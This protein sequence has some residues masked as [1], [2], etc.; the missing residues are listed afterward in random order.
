M[1]PAGPDEPGPTPLAPP[2]GAVLA[3]R[4]RVLEALGQGGMGVVVRALDLELS[5]EVALKLLVGSEG[6]QL[7]RMRREG[8]VA[9]SLRHPGIVTLHELGEHEGRP[10]LVYELVERAR[11]LGGLLEEAP[12]ERLLGWVLDA[13]RALAF[14]HARG[15]VHRDVKPDNLLIDGEGRLR[16]ADFGLATG[17]QV[18]RLTRSGQR[19]GTPRYMSPEQARGDRER[20]G[21]PA[22]VWGLGVIL[23]RVLTGRLPFDTA[24]SVAELMAQIVHREPPPILGLDPSVPPGL[25]AVC[26]RALSKAPERRYAD[27]GELADDLARALASPDFAP[28]APREASTPA[29]LRGLLIAGMA[30]AAVFLV[31]AP[32]LDPLPAGPAGG[33][34]P[35]ESASVPTVASTLPR[36]PAWVAALPAEERPPL[37]LPPGLA[38][39]EGREVVNER[40]GSRL[41]WIPP[42]RFTR[43]REDP[44]HAEEGPVHAVTLRRGLFLGVH[45]LDWGRYR[46][47]C[48]ATARPLPSPFLVLRVRLE[49]RELE[50]D[51]RPFQDDHPVMNVCW[52]D[53][54]DYCDWAGLRLPSEAEWERAAR[55][56]DTRPYPWGWDPPDAGRCNSLRKGAGAAPARSHALGSHPAGAGPFGTQDQAGNVWEWVQDWEQA[57]GP[58]EAIDPLGT[59]GVRRMVR[60]GSWVEEAPRA[61]RRRGVQPELIS[62]DVGFRVAR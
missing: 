8:E 38:W 39:G 58:G 51:P 42:G 43:G 53:A 26:Q 5:R 37:P 41:V 31:R 15:V 19:L 18:D 34:G 28:A 2:P 17:P 35:T 57:Y 62:A 23:Y 14:A 45:E 20:T 21:P 6:R 11:T 59:G 40:D 12:R 50:A 9:A 10:F 7:E 52:Q 16:V 24:V 3:G 60:G 32:R 44:Q 55:G 29:P 1:T 48:A 46:R 4:Y 33:A 22:D 30:T 49:S 25:A 56:R 36:A 13:A 27:A 61:T 47:F 54:R